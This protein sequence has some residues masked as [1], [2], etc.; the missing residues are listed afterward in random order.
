MAPQAPFQLFHRAERAP[1][2]TDVDDDAFILARCRPQSAAHRLTPQYFRQG[3]AKVDDDVAV[4]VVPSLCEDA[5]RY[6][7]LDL[8][9]F[10]TRQ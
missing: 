8:A 7:G 10:V 5:D 1:V 3:R 2:G 4:R 9:A 6:H